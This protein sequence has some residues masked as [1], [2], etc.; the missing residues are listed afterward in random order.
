MIVHWKCKRFLSTWLIAIVLYV[1]ARL[2]WSWWNNKKRFVDFYLIPYTLFSPYWFQLSFWQTVFLI[3]LICAR[4]SLISFYLYKIF[5]I[6]Y[7]MVLLLGLCII[8]QVICFLKW[9]EGCLFFLNVH[10]TSPTATISITG[11][12][13]TSSV[14]VN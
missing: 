4:I 3:L 10:K 14:K 1:F 12:L 5:S 7:V 13:N 8:L 6:S 9:W 11:V 2:F